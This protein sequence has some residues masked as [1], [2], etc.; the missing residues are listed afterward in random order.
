MPVNTK[1]SLLSLALLAITPLQGQA[2]QG[3]PVPTPALPGT[4]D[5]ALPQVAIGPVQP[6]ITPIALTAPESKGGAVLRLFDVQIRTDAKG[7]H[8]FQRSMIKFNTPASLQMA[9]NLTLQWQPSFGGVTVNAARI[10]RDGQVIDLM[11][12]GGKFTSLRQEAQLGAFQTTGT[13]TAFMPVTGLKVGDM[14]EFAYTIDAFNPALGGHVEEEYFVYPGMKFDQFRLSASH[15]KASKVQV[16]FGP[17]LPAPRRSEAGGFVFYTA[18]QQAVQLPKLQTGDAMRQFGRGSVQISDFASW[19]QV[20]EVMRPLFDKGAALAPNSPLN[21][22]IAKIAAASSDPMVRASMALRLVQRQTRYFAELQGLGG[23]TPIPADTVWDRKIGDCKGKTVL[24]LALLRGLQIDAEPLLVSTKRG[25]GTDQVLPMPGRFDHVIVLARIGGKDYW[26]DG[27]RMDGGRVPDLESPDFLWGLPL[28]NTAK[29]LVPIPVDT[30]QRPQSD[31]AFDFDASAGLDVP[32]KVR[33]TAVLR[34]DLGLALAQAFD[35]LGPEDLDE[36]L[37]SLWKSQRSD[38]TI[39]AVT[40]ELDP[41]TGEVRI[42][43]TGTA[44]LDWNR[45]GKTPTYRYEASSSR[46]GVNLVPDRD[47]PPPG[48]DPIAVERRYETLRETI[49]L[50]DGGAGFTL[51]GSN[52][53]ETVGGVRYDRKA[54]LTGNRF[55]L[56]VSLASPR[57]ELNLAQA[58]AAD[59]ASDD[60]WERPLY[61]RLPPALVAKDAGSNASAANTQIEELIDASNLTEAR[62]QIDGRLA[63]T[64][65]D[66]DVLA[67]SGRVRF[68]EGDSV[69]AKRDLDMALAINSRQPLALR[70]KAQMLYEQGNHD[71]ALLVLDR[72]VLISPDQDQLYTDRSLVREAAGDKEGALADRT[73]LVARHP[74]M[75][76]LRE[77]QTRLLFALGRGDEALASARE[78]QKLGKDDDR[79]L[80]L[81][82][83]VLIRKGARAEAIKELASTSTGRQA[84]LAALVRMEYGLWANPDQLLSDARLAAQTYPTNELPERALDALAKDPGRMAKLLAT[85]DAAAQKPGAAKDRIAIARALALRAT[86]NAAPLAAALTALEL[87]H[88]GDPST[89]NQVCWLRAIWRIDL[90]AARASCEAALRPARRAAYVDSLAMVE[91]QSGNFA[92]AISLYSEAL[93]SLPELAPTRFGRGLARLSTGDAGGQ[94]DLAL[95]RNIDLEIDAIFARYGFKPLAAR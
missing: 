17:A 91:L 76:W 57:L 21:A 36:M 42:G 93:R 33:G 65:R 47:N 20:A 27:T 94:A 19:Q 49:L 30:F 73:I 9:T 87:A 44:K 50:P 32:A 78:V 5:P 86:G 68:I 1:L 43:F 88:P 85:Y 29:G 7:V 14:L 84:S 31:W 52:I 3:A 80:V 23:Y 25:P 83:D 61:L 81:L 62:R 46:M 58:L 18:E 35:V 11:A 51:D 64:P 2:P 60:L 53:Q 22:E 38:L 37:R 6:W 28:T 63:A 55:E 59:S 8:E 77:G 26:L 45:T 79:S 66:A 41:E 24:L 40:H 13:L 71:D 54:S 34:G 70:T 10:Y 89:A 74:E 90:V 69:A 75:A 67:L 72:A 82:I 56:V 92:K 95:A 48:D 39:N 16:R 4:P 15:A 12:Q